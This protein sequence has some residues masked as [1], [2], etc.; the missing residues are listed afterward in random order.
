MA[1]SRKSHA[2]ALILA[3][4]AM[5]TAAALLRA[6]AAAPHNPD[7]ASP[8]PVLPLGWS[9]APYH[10]ANGSD[11]DDSRWYMMTAIN[12]SVRPATRILLAD[13]PYDAGL[14]IL[15]RRG[16]A[17]IRQVATSDAEVTVE[18]AHAYGRYAFRVIMPPATSAELAI[19]LTDAD[20]QPQVSAWLEPELAAH[21]RQLAVLF[22]TIAGLIAAA[23]AI[24]AGLAVMTGHSAPR[25][26]AAVLLGV[27]LV[28][29]AAAGLFDAI[30]VGGV[31]GPYG[32][33]AMLAGLTLA[34]GV[35]LVDTIAP[36]GRFWS[37]G[38]LRGV[39]IGLVILSVAAA[40][41]VPGTMLLTE[42]TVVVG[43]AL[44]AAHLVH[45]GLAGA[46]S[47]RVA[48]PSAT[49]FALVATAA[50]LSALGAFQ[51]DPAAPGIV[52]GFAATGSVLLALAIAAGE[53]MAILPA[54][55]STIAPLPDKRVPYAP[56]DESADA[57]A[58]IGASY[59]GVFEFDLGR[60]TVKLSPEAAGLIGLRNGPETF[61][62]AD[63]LARVHSDD[64]EVYR[65]AIARFCSQKGLAFRV[66]FRIRTEHG[67]Y[68]WLE[69]RASALGNGASV[70]RYLGLVADVTTRKES[71]PPPVAR[72]R[73]RL[74]G[75]RTRLGLVDELERLGTDL[76]RGILAFVDIDRFKSVH[77]SLGDAGGDSVLVSVA[78]RLVALGRGGAVV[79]RVGGDA[80][81]L[82]F[83]GPDPNA[84]TLGERI[85]E[86]LNEPHAW[87]DRSAFAPASVGLAL[88]RD[89]EDPFDLIKNA[90]L[91][92]RKAKLDGGACARL[93]GRELE[94]S[95]VPDAVALDAALR[96]S[97]A[98]GDMDLVYQP[99][100]RLAD[101]SVA[102]F[103]AL[104]RW[105]HPERG[106]LAPDDFI[107]HAERT[108]FIVELGRF[109]LSRAADDLGRWQK[110]F[111]LDPPLFASV[112]MSRRQ[113]DER[114]LEKLVS[115]ILGADLANGSLKIELTESAVSSTAGILGGLQRL[116]SCGVSL[117]ID[118]FG[119]GASGLSELKN[120]P[121]DM[122]KI[123]KSFLD[124]SGPEGGDGAVVLRSIVNLA[125][126]LGRV[127]VLEGVEN[128]G[129][130]A[131]LKEIG[132][133]F[134]QGFVF[135]PPL[136]GNE[137]PGFI[138]AHRRRAPDDNA[139][140]TSGVAGVGRQA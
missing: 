125:H 31:G 132:C 69:L 96:R 60:Q 83:P 123:D 55:R 90:E 6:A 70:D 54:R 99:I 119:T 84:L 113:L 114:E 87:G 98:K 118:D 117:C 133:D 62:E 68:C 127:V 139:G 140:R 91:S 42:V 77:A 135:A 8:R 24:M 44:M 78:D 129:D 20:A 45:Q 126:E 59:Q 13:Q 73:D 122:V 138:A 137:V 104:L 43:A 9:L 131:W 71:D 5:C 3:F 107:A 57:I 16:R 28:C 11:S 134:A 72:D 110:K 97:L 121:F 65:D 116:R 17:A 48:A 82:L 75:L 34:A 102:G 67:H 115:L 100:M 111:P 56:P 46:Q 35:R 94:A 39:I 86:Q 80:F 112:N 101:R 40:V 19:R 47:A 53:G 92:L 29:L 51:S 58:A 49:V 12:Q 85:V 89:A 15:P 26:A 30:G 88:G 103:E 38:S 14:R 50:A 93:Y 61:T 66:E 2:L 79:F 18:N 76:S 10:A 7:F 128:E 37:P 130:A 4:I 23:L 1:A 95:A 63:W 81:A 105:K 136:A 124:R 106:L 120:I 21:N 27:L 74:T 33:T 52:G 22:A 32:T 64:R 25:W 36:F 41:G 108:G 109:A